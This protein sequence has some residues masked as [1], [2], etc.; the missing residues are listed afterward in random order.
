[1]STIREKEKYEVMETPTFLETPTSVFFSPPLSFSFFF[2]YNIFQSRQTHFLQ[3]MERSHTQWQEADNAYCL[4]TAADPVFTAD[5]RISLS[6]RQSPTCNRL[7]MAPNKKSNQLDDND[8]CREK[9]YLCT[10]PA[11]PRR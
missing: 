6:L 3:V 9:L 10:P 1:M 2:E 4:D 7:N 5:K 11:T 8:T